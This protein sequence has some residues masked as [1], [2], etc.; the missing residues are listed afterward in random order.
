M[1]ASSPPSKTPRDAP[2]RLSDLP[3][4]TWIMSR[5]FTPNVACAILVLPLIVPVCAVQILR[6]AAYLDQTRTG[7][8]CVARYRPIREALL[9]VVVVFAVLGPFGSVAAYAATA[10]DVEAIVT[11]PFTLF[12][13]W[14]VAGTVVLML[15]MADNV[16]TPVGPETPRHDLHTLAGLAQLPG[17]RLTAL[18]LARRVVTALPDGTV[19]ATVAA[20]DALHRAYV[21]LG[22]RPGHKRRAYLI[23]GEDQRITAH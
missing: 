15:C 1:S 10:L 11:V 3:R 22:F 17:T 19:V 8:V 9:S 21:R 20:N 4:T 2:A 14:I 23:V 5:A 12:M 6:R 13:T 16:A 18:H 7:M